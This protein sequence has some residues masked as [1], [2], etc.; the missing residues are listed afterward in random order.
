MCDHP[1]CNWRE[2]ERGSSRH[3]RDL[4]E[5]LKASETKSSGPAR[6]L[7]AITVRHRMQLTLRREER[8]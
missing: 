6:E 8:L 5:L 7:I 4:P 1:T 3:V 2:A